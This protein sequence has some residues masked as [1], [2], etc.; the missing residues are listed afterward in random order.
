MDEQLRN[1]IFDAVE[2]EPCAKRLGISLVA[3]EKGYSRVEMIYDPARMNNIYQRAHGGAIFTLIDEAFETASQ[4]RGRIAVAL[5]VN[6]SYMASPDSGARLKAEAKEI[7][8]SNR[9]S[10]FD[11]T[12]TDESGQLIAAC[13]ATAY[14]TGKPVLEQLLA[15]GKENVS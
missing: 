10:N 3:L 4:T 7:S 8:S 12:V 6:V 15:F 14:R 5:N 1:A 2:N 11:I 13:R 9:V